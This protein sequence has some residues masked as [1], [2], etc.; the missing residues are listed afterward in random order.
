MNWVLFRGRSMVC[1]DSSCFK[2]AVNSEWC[3]VDS[4]HFGF[5]TNYV[6]SV[7]Y[8]FWTV[9]TKFEFLIFIILKI[10]PPLNG[11]KFNFKNPVV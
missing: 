7:L 4:A 8:I 11:I 10:C 6:D 9:I 5:K 2:F 1:L 3:A